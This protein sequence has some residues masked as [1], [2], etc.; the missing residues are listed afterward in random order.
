AS[1]RV[2]DVIRAREDTS[3]WRKASP[4]TLAGAR[5]P[6]ALDLVALAAAGALGRLVTAGDALLGPAA[7][8]ADLPARTVRVGG[9]LAEGGP[10][11]GRRRRRLRR[12][13]GRRGRG[14]GGAAEG[15]EGGQGQ[16]GAEHPPILPRRRA[17]AKRHEHPAGPREGPPDGRRRREAGRRPHAERVRRRAPRRRG[18]HPAPGVAEALPGDRLALYR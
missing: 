16:Q 10:R 1:G 2:C 6:D 12:G 17:R 18:E 8:L 13:S 14:G 7:A 4:L 15:E 11:W 5:A 9:A 3:E